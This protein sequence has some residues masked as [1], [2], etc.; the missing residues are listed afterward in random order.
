MPILMYF[1]VN[2]A[3]LS[4]NRHYNAYFIYFFFC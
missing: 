3:Y 4:K 1:A 2:E